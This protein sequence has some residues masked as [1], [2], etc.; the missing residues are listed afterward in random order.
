MFNIVCCVLCVGGG[1]CC[2]LFIFYVI[3][4]FR[5]VLS[6][7]VIAFLSFRFLS[8]CA[9]AHIYVFDIVKNK[10]TK[11]GLCVQINLSHTVQERLMHMYNT[12]EYIL[13]HATILF[14]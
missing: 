1:V 13:K 11:N 5:C 2:V 12:C 8:S 10:T 6:L 4:H 7:P 3:S 14:A 9:S